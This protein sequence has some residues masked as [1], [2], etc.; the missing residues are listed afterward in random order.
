MELKKKKKQHSSRR[1]IGRWWEFKS[2]GKASAEQTSMLRVSGEKEPARQKKMGRALQVEGITY[3]EILRQERLE[4]LRNS[5][6][7]MCGWSRIKG[8]GVVGEEEWGGRSSGKDFGF[9]CHHNGPIGS[10]G[11]G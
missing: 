10:H 2:S 8:G 3:A 6:K 5:K 1:K 9:Y 11:A 4:F 7:A